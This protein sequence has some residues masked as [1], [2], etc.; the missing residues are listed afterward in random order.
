MIWGD[1]FEV[2]KG[3]GGAIGKDISQME[4]LGGD[5]F[6][7]EHWVTQL[8]ISYCFIRICY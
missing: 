2:G 1:M 3:G 4:C 8:V 6:P 7:E 5:T